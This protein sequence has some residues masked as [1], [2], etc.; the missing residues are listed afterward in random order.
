MPRIK[1]ATPEEIVAFIEGMDEHLSKEQCIAIMDE[2]GCN[3]NNRFSAEFRKFGE[4]NKD[5]TLEEKIAL[6]SEFE[7]G[8]K[9]NECRLNDNGTITLIFGV[10]G[11]KGDWSCPCTPIKN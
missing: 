9:V 3:K 10:D 7:S 5:R 2:Q 11:K 1:K 4:A 8:N 6:F